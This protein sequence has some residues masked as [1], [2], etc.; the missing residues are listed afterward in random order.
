MKKTIISTLFYIGF[1]GYYFAQQDPMISQYVFNGLYLNPGYA[2]SHETS[3]LTM[4]YR[5]QWVNLEGSPVTQFASLYLPFAE[6]NLGAGL[7]FMSDKIGVTNQ[8]RI[9]LN[10]AYHLP[11]G[12]GKL[13]FGLKSGVTFFR[14]KVDELTVWDENDPKYSGGV[15]SSTQPNVGI[16]AYYYL[17][18]FYAGVA[19]PYLIN[20][21]PGTFL[22]VDPKN[23]QRSERHYYLTSGYVYTINDHIALKPSMLLKYVLHAPLEAD[24]NLHVL[25]KN[26]LWLGGSYRTGDSFIGMVDFQISEQFK[27]GY[28]HDFTI[29]RL[30][31][32][33]S[34]T[35]EIIVSYDFGKEAIKMK[36]PRYF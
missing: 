34:G 31:N 23:P 2:G 9:N 19:V 3:N 32:S 12:K 13:A 4:M 10:F 5:N 29:T 24:F 25:L 11:T 15:I 18:K 26:T 16:G 36:T 17:P 14:A 28:A 35:H 30:K 21:K 22:G 6:Q 20:Y 7:I 8:T 33:S 1:L 27:V